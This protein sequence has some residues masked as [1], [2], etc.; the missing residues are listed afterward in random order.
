VWLE[1]LLLR[2]LL[3]RLLT[4]PLR[5]PCRMMPRFTTLSSSA[6]WRCLTAGAGTTI[7]PKHVS[8]ARAQRPSVASPSSASMARSR[9][10]IFDFELH[11]FG[12]THHEQTGVKAKHKS[13][14]DQGFP[15]RLRAA[16]HTSTGERC[17][18]ETLRQSPK[19]PHRLIL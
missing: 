5:L 4:L 14:A 15:P 12:R 2:L 7:T 10:Y 18:P 19:T 17:V 1:E 9:D 8:I 16:L 13:G 11:A 3:P 6:S